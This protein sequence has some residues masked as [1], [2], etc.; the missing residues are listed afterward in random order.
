MNLPMND[1]H[2]EKKSPQ[3]IEILHRAFRAFNEAT[4]QL[5][6]SSDELNEALETNQNYLHNIMESLPTGVIVVDQNNV[7]TTFNKTAGAITGLNLETCLNKPLGE[8]FPIYLFQ[9]LVGR[10]TKEKKTSPI[11]ER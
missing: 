5:Q 9:N 1:P 10:T 4:E 3:E 11:V 7:I 8:L 2:P 6:N